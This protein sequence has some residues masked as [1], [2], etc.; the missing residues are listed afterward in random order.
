MLATVPQAKVL[1]LLALAALL[2]VLAVAML[3]LSAGHVST[4]PSTVTAA[5]LN[6]NASPAST[7]R[8]TPGST[9][10]AR[11]AYRLSLGR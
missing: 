6:P 4:G 8:V 7:A 5:G 2:A 10:H 1:T 11:Y 3:A 9:A